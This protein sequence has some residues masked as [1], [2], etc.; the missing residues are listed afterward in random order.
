MVGSIETTLASLAMQKQFCAKLN[1]KGTLTIVVDNF[2]ENHDVVKLQFSAELKSK[3]FLCY[4]VDNPFLAIKK[5][6]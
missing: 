5:T 2:L 6:G 1:G 3:R 4:G